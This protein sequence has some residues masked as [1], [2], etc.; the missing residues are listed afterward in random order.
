MVAATENALLE[1]VRA[2]FGSTLQ[3]CGTHPGTWDDVAIRHMLVSP[4]SIY[5]A[6]LGFGPG[7]TR[8][9]VE[10]HWVFYVVAE[11]LNGE[12]S[13][14]L[15]IYQM[16]DRLVGGIN[17]QRFGPSSNMH[18]TKAQNL[19]T[20]TQDAAGVALYGLYFSAIT[21]VSIGP[22]IAT[23]DDFE[24]HYQTWQMPDGTPAFKAHI[25]VNGPPPK[26]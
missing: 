18:L 10:S 3:Q 20:D 4:P 14:H 26:E 17:G 1:A 16:I 6:W 21:P 8:A 7:R 23:L 2:L 24:R 15:G 25:N 19:Y 13:D 12:D 5:V 22:D 11:R 9:E